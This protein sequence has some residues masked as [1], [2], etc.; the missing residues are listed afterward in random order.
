M[1]PSRLVGPMNAILRTWW[2]QGDERRREFVRASRLLYHTPPPPPYYRALLG[3]AS[4][5]IAEDRYELRH[6]LA[7]IVAQMACEVVV[8]QTLTPL[9]KG[10]KPPRTFSLEGG[11]L[12]KYTLLTHD[13]SITKKPFWKPFVRYAKL[14][15]KVVH[16]GARVGEADAHKALTMATQFVEHVEKVREEA[17]R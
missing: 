2:D 11:A 16:R 17:L 14:R 10:T 7:V 15:H 5:L 12:S 1:P 4:S 8:E 3:L 9:L 6:E 13:R